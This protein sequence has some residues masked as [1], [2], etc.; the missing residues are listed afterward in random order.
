MI[1]AVYYI[2]GCRILHRKLWTVGYYIKGFS[3]LH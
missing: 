2:E 3:I 1:A